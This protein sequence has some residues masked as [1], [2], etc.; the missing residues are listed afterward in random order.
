VLAG[1]DQRLRMMVGRGMYDGFNASMLI[2][3]D[4]DFI[5]DHGHVHGSRRSELTNY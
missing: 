1:L 4:V 3:I 2:G 5:R